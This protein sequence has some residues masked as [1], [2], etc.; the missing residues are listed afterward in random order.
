MVVL[1]NLLWAGR[2]SDSYG[3]RDRAR[4]KHEFNKNVPA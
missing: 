4:C 1:W 2:E 3:A